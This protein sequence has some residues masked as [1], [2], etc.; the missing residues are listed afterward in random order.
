MS[1]PL[2]SIGKTEGHMKIAN[3]EENFGCV[4]E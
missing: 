1:I 4:G 2:Q 3:T